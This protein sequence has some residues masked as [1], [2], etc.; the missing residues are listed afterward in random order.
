MVFD[1]D[2]TLVAGDSFGLFLRR[3]LTRHPGR[4]LAAVLSAPAWVPALLLAPTRTLAERYLVWLA[5]VGMDEAAFTAAAGDFAAEHAAPAGGRVAAAALDRLHQ[6]LQ[7]G[8]R[9]VVATGCAAPLAQQLCAVI[10]LDGVDVVSST[11]TRGRWGLPARTV[12]ARGRGKLRA[13]EAAGIR[14]PVDH[15]YS[16]SSSDLPLLRA[17]RMPH[18][19]DPRPRDWARLRR[20]L[21]PDVDLVRWADRPTDGDSSTDR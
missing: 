19:V 1:L 9:V 21:G 13:L 20:E 10:G 17:A 4:L 14:L 11:M 12:P 7:R 5:A 2:G 3:L 16:D 18:V 6:H 8:D 15:A